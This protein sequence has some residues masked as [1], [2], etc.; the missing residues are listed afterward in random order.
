MVKIAYVEIETKVVLGD[1]GVVHPEA[2]AIVHGFA[3]PHKKA[4]FINAKKG[5][6]FFTIGTVHEFCHV[7][8]LRHCEK[9]N[10][11]MFKLPTR[12]FLCK[13]CYEV[14][15]EKLFKG[16]KVKTRKPLI[17]SKVMVP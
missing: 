5:K 11:L 2:P 14:L 12:P 9:K 13:K 17:K 6:E 3:F 7:I 10:C 4:I 15:N 1:G 8:G 16:D